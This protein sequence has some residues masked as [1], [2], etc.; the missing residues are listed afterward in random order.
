[1]RK[2]FLALLN[3]V[4][5][6]ALVLIVSVSIQ[7]NKQ[8]HVN[9]TINLTNG[10]N[11]TLTGSSHAYRNLILN[12]YLNS[13]YGI[14]PSGNLNSGTF[15]REGWRFKT[16]QNGCAT[17]STSDT[18]IAGPTHS[19]AGI[20]IPG[21][22]GIGT[23]SGFTPGTAGY[24]VLEN[25]IEGLDFRRI[26]NKT[27][28]IGFWAYS[29]VT[30]TYGLS[31][32]NAAKNRVYVTT[33]SIGSAATWTY[34]E[35]TIP[36]GDTSGSWNYDTSTGLLIRWPL[37]AGTDWDDATADTWGSTDELCTSAGTANVLGGGSQPRFAITAVHLVEGSTVGSLERRPIAVENALVGRYY[38]SGGVEAQRHGINVTNGQVYYRGVQFQ[39]WMRTTPAVTVTSS[40]SANLGTTTAGGVTNKSFYGQSTASSTSTGQY[41]DFSWTADAQLSL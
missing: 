28:T 4:G 7:G 21:V 18:Q 1:M 34:I 25:Y 8:D 13:L 6:L 24:A 40:N 5:V 36:T 2:I 37:G 17:Y 20:Y 22:A 27:F 14:A 32:S 38:Q 3:T 16:D 29:Q 35:K 31:I 23:G 41:I 26:S 11:A 30:G 33:Y 19:Q 12:P 9:G 15:I 39:T 10:S